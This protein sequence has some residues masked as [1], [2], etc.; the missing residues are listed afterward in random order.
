MNSCVNS[1]CFSPSSDQRP[2]AF[3]NS[4]TTLELY[5][6]VVRTFLQSRCKN[7]S[8]CVEKKTNSHGDCCILL[9]IEGVCNGALRALGEQT[10]T[11]ITLCCIVSFSSVRGCRLLTAGSVAPR[12]C[13]CHKS[14]AHSRWHRRTSFTAATEPDLTQHRSSLH[15]FMHVRCTREDFTTE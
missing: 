13:V 7:Q 15:C 1:I 11:A 10:A 9:A 4:I 8:K 2:N 3:S 5:R 14:A 6:C 12:W